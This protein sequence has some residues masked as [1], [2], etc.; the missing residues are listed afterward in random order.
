MRIKCN[1]MYGYEGNC[2]RE[3]TY[4]DGCLPTLYNNISCTRGKIQSTK[5]FKASYTVGRL[6]KMYT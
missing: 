2:I 1:T 3:R 5:H 4:K 6:W